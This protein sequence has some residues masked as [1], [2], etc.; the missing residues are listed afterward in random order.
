MLFKDIFLKTHNKP[1]RLILIR[2]NIK[3]KQKFKKTYYPSLIETIAPRKKTFLTV[4]LKNSL[5][6]TLVVY[7]YILHTVQPEEQEQVDICTDRW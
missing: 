4:F 1:S 3:T 2:K 5:L 6:E 7:S